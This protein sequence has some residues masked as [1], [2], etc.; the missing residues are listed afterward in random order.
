VL[1]ATSEEHP[2]LLPL[3]GEED[4]VQLVLEPHGGKFISPA[5]GFRLL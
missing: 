3:E 2:V 4:A 5:F 1:T